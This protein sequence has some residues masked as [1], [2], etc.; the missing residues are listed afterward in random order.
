MIVRRPSVVRFGPLGHLQLK[1]TLELWGAHG[2]QD[3]G[4]QRIIMYPSLSRLYRLDTVFVMLTSAGQGRAT[5]GT[6][7]G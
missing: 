5:A 7:I 1:P 3:V 2:W 4:S 6:P